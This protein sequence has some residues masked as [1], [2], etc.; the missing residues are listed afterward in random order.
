MAPGSSWSVCMVLFT[1]SNQQPE[2]YTALIQ[3]PSLRYIISDTAE[4]Q[5][6]E[7]PAI[8]S[9]E[10][11]YQTTAGVQIL[12]FNS[13]ILQHLQY[14]LLQSHRTAQL[15]FTGLHQRYNKMLKC[16]TLSNNLNKRMNSYSASLLSYSL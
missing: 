7:L 9:L 6:R 8:S 11:I 14:S 4:Q 3:H 13:D 12:I 5:T 15:C 16:I 10:T 2:I 1:L